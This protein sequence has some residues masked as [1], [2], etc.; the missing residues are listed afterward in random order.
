MLLNDLETLD[1]KENE[2]L[3]YLQNCIEAINEVVTRT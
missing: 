1:N 3:Y 2:Y